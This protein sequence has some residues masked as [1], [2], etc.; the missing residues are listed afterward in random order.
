MRTILCYNPATC[1]VIQYTIS[2]LDGNSM[3][4]Q[5]SA[6]SIPSAVSVV[7]EYLR[8]QIAKHELPPG[9]WL[10]QDAIA[11][12]LGTSRMPLREALRQLEGEGYVVFHPRRGWAVAALSVEDIE[13]INVMRM[14]LEG[15]AARLGTARVTDGDLIQME[16]LLR[17]MQDLW[18][19]EDRSLL[20]EQDYPFH[21]ILYAAAGRARLLQRIHVLQ[22][23]ARR[24]R[25]VDITLPDTPNWA[26]VEH[27]HIV[28]ACRSRDV[29]LVE[30]LTR[31][32]IA[33]LTR[34][35]IAYLQSH[36]GEGLGG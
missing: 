15:L 25:S 18:N 5:T 34:R 3:I 10:R 9:A 11:A 32:H 17:R 29:E 20:F 30:Q 16:R 27:R 2:N 31:A 26:I 19:A 33:A 24:Y 23:N 22:R 8:D 21:D 7:Y 36:P 6:P 13:E 12:D 35:T 28:E 1:V 14:G 4:V